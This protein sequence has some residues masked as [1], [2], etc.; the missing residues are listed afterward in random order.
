MTR[1]TF[2]DSF[3]SG[4][5]KIATHVNK[6]PIDLDASPRAPLEVPPRPESAWA[7]CA[8]RQEMKFKVSKCVAHK[9]QRSLQPK[10]LRNLVGPLHKRE[11]GTLILV[12]QIF[13]IMLQHELGHKPPKEA[14]DHLHQKDG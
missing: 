12:V 10:L 13:P 5:E 1:Q 14:D 8:S 4:C 9:T 2:R 6:K 3:A 7:P 11:R